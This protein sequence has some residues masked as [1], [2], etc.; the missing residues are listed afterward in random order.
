MAKFGGTAAG[1]SLWLAAFKKRPF[2]WLEAG[3]EDLASGRLIAGE[4]LAGSAGFAAGFG[5]S[6]YPSCRDAGGGAAFFST[7][8]VPLAASV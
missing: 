3:F 1:L 6:R 2:T 4:G 8:S 7:P 5:A